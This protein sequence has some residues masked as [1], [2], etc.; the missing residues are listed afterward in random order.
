[1]EKFHGRFRLVITGAHTM[2]SALITP[3]DILPGFRGREEIKKPCHS[4]TIN[5]L[6]P[7]PLYIQVKMTAP[8]STP[9][10]NPGRKNRLSS[11]RVSRQKKAGRCHTI[12][13]CRA[14]V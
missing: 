5:T 14:A 13:S 6:P 1:M 8:H 12:P 10:M 9:K 4:A 7:L 3:D 2:T 11:S